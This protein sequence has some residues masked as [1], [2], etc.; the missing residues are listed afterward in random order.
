MYTFI[1]TNGYGFL[2]K[3]T[4]IN[5]FIQQRKNIIYEINILPTKQ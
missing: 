4:S 1:Y 5:N 3:I 2:Y